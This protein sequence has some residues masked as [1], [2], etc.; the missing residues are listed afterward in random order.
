MNLCVC[1]SV[2]GLFAR[3]MGDYGGLYATWRVSKNEMKNGIFPAITFPSS[4][5]FITAKELYILAVI[6]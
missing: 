3:C 4:F 1:V 6:I 5:H 2:S